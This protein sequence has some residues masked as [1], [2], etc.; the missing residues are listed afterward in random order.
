MQESY[1][2]LSPEKVIVHLNQILIN[3]EKRFEKDKAH[4]VK[5]FMQSKTTGWFWKRRKVTEAEATALMY[6]AIH[7]WDSGWS[8]IS[9]TYEY[10][11]YKA[12]PI[13]KAALNT[14]TD[15]QLTISDHDWIFSQ[16]S[17]EK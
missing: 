4:C 5:C 13:L 9:E 1:V 11:K 15:L 12:K 2:F 3:A 14:E 16:H 10:T 6:K 7:S 17:L 8:N